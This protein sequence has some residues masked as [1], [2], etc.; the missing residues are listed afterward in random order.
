[1]P[2]SIVIASSPGLPPIEIMS[3]FTYDRDDPWAKRNLRQIV[4][5]PDVYPPS[6][7]ERTALEQVII[8]AA[9]RPSGTEL[10]RARTSK[11][12][13]GGGRRCWLECRHGSSYNGSTLTED[14]EDSKPT[15]HYKE[16]VKKD[17]IVNKN[18]T[19]RGS[20]KNAGKKMKRRCTTSKPDADATCPFRI[21]LKLLPGDH[22]EIIG[23][24]TDCA[25]HNHIHLHRSEMRHSTSHMTPAE[26]DLAATVLTNAHGGSAQNILSDVTGKTFSQQ[27]LYYVKHKLDFGHPPVPV[28]DSVLLMEHLQAGA[29]EGHLRYAAIFHEVTDSTLV[30][31]DKATKRKQ[32]ASLNTLNQH[33]QAEDWS[34]AEALSIDVQVRNCTVDARIPFSLDQIE[35]LLELGVF[36]SPM[37]AGLRVGQKVLLAVA[38]ARVDEAQLFE[39]FPEVLMFDVTMGTNNEGRPLGISLS[40][41]GNMEVFTPFR[42]FLPAQTKFA[43]DWTLSYAIAT[44]MGEQNCS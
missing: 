35:D 17:N 7:D 41:D 25:T 38:W 10:T 40:I 4:L 44:I 18:A 28:S 19:K 21:T 8:D 24:F 22:W 14:D 33:L 43:F 20:T 6:W 36:L 39:Q 11:D 23:Q 1:M 27:Q 3:S 30:A 13:F 34:V 29:A 31:I 16:G 32:P 42:V 5:P 26:K 9:L 12:K 37:L 15:S 2:L